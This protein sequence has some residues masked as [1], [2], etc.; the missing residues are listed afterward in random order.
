MQIEAFAA[1]G[2]FYRGNLHT[3]ST[4]SDGKLHAE[5]VC[6]RYRARGYD[7]ICL[8]DHFH[9]AYKFAIADTRAY[10]TD[11][12]T[13]IIGA[14]CHAPAT[15]NGEAWHI[16]AVGLPLEFAKYSEGE[17]GPQVAQRCLDAGAFVA[18]PHPEWYALS[19]ADA[20][21]IPGAHAVEVYNHTSQ[22]L[23][24]R[25]GGSYYLDDLLNAGRR[26]NAL[27]CDD[28]HWVVEADRNRDAFGGWVMV[29][30]EANEPDA[31]VE[32]LKN[33]HYY[34]SQGPMIEDISIHGDNIEIKCSAAFQISVVGRASKNEKIS[35]VDLTSATL[36]WKKFAGD[37]ARAVV[38]DA[39]GKI[40]WSNPFYL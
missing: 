5:E 19:I 29:K 16:L 27:A 36:P 11:R 21:T 39:S 10:R 35:G 25:G 2:K 31:L 3:H 15:E 12:F 24:G 14:E 34:S 23:N 40:A 9:A 37:W 33:G 38:I 4:V 20:A 26:I 6:E 8:S 22:V 17:T 18:I 30:S 7:F 1:P 32:A 28:A 13:T